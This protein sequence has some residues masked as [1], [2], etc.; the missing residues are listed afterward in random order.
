MDKSSK[1]CCLTAKPDGYRELG[2]VPSL[3]QAKDKPHQLLLREFTAYSP[4]ARDIP[5]RAGD[6]GSTAESG[7]TGRFAL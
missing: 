5:P 2:L 1:F 7:S 6:S 3:L 4:P